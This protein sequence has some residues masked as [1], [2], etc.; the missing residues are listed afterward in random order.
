M[1]KIFTDHERVAIKA[2]MLK[3]GAAVLRKKGIRGVS[4]G[5]IVKGVRIATGSFYS[6]YNTKEDL[7][8]EIVKREESLM[9]EQIIAVASQELDI[10][11]KIRKIFQE[12]YLRED[13]LVYCLPRE[14]VE[15]ISRKMP[16]EVLKA[17]ADNAYKI[18]RTILA[19]CDLE[20]SQENIEV[21]LS[22]Q[23]MMKM[24]ANS[25]IPQS[26]FAR[27]KILNVLVEAFVDYFCGGDKT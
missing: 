22:M 2:D 27:K 20:V 23:S 18:H 14:D 19:A 24:A 11:M 9:L 26:W 12:V 10:K 21:S 4:I 3:V 17:D 13:S 6:F 16:P 7:I 5:D 8:W 25:E 1:P 15:Y